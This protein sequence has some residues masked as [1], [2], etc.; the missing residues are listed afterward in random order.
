MALPQGRKLANVQKLVP[1][2]ELGPLFQYVAL[3]SEELSGAAEGVVDQRS[4]DAVDFPRR[5]LAV[6]GVGAL[7]GFLVIYLAE[8]RR[9]AVAGRDAARDHA[10]ALQVGSSECREL[11]KDEMLC[12]T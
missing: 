6:S 11:A 2:E 3:R 5:F 10:C 12:R 1:G 7:S 4:D 8:F 9:H